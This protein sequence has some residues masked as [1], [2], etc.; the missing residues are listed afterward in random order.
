M[1]LADHHFDF[2]IAPDARAAVVNLPWRKKGSLYQDHH[3]QRVLLPRISHPRERLTFSDDGQEVAL[4]CRHAAWTTYR[5]GP[6]QDFVYELNVGCWNSEGKLQQ[7]N[8]D[9][10]PEDH[11]ALQFSSDGKLLVA[12][13]PDRLIFRDGREGTRIRRIDG[14]KLAWPVYHCGS[15]PRPRQFETKQLV[16]LSHDGS[17]VLTAEYDTVRVWNGMTGQTVCTL[18]QS[19][20]RR[21]GIGYGLV[22]VA[23]ALAWAWQSM[24]MVSG[25]EILRTG[26][27]ARSWMFVT[28]IFCLY[29]ALVPLVGRRFPEGWPE[30]VAWGECL[31]ALVGVVALIAA[32]GG[33]RRAL[34][35]T[36]TLV[37]LVACIPWKPAEAVALGHQ[38]VQ[39]FWPRAPY[40]F[41]NVFGYGL[42]GWFPAIL[43]E[44]LGSVAY[45]RLP[46][47]LASAASDRRLIHAAAG[48]GAEGGAQ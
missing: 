35:A 1:R 30:Y 3:S 31:A 32:F 18:W 24:R 43:C 36:M 23:C 10:N 42:L 20:A 44:F 9:L 47:R 38:T 13:R 34:F 46:R 14:L 25:A 2:R 21:V 7:R 39:W 16:A 5:T 45:R 15:F 4:A 29:L 41:L 26:G 22:L 28:G 48:G 27:W 11:G 40:A 19:R 37:L 12:V 33:E 8:V 17:R 6:D